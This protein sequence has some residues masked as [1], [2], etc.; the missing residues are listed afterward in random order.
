M[1]SRCARTLLTLLLAA[2][3][4]GGGTALSADGAAPAGD[5]A[6]DAVSDVPAG[7]FGKLDILFLIDNSASTMDDKQNLHRALP[8][9]FD[10]LKK[11]RGGLPDLHIGAITTDVGAGNRPLANGGCPVPGGDRGILQVQPSC[12]LEGGARFMTSATGGT[13]NNF[14]GSIESALTCLTRIGDYGCGYEHQLQAIRLAL[15]EGVTVQNQGFLRADAVLAIIM[16]TDEDDCSAD[17][18]SDLFTDDATFANT[19]ASFRCA[20]VGHLCDGK[21]PPIAPF[22]VPLESCQANPGGRLIKVSDVVAAVR[23]HKAQPDQQILVAGLIGWPTNPV[24]ARYRYVTT[25]QGVDVGPI[26]QSALTGEAS[27][28]L[29]LKAFVESFGAAGSFSSICEEDYAP[30]LRRI[31]QALAVR[32]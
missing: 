14:P 11:A 12:Q 30:A 3:C 31:G 23:G 9:F 19:T 20:Q 5:G 18:Q 4:G 21:S 7:P 22:D 1:S 13:V 28:G 8:A 27:V 25:N 16:L 6:A 15:D 26:C 29:R 32:F 10:E 2:G 17:P 24:G